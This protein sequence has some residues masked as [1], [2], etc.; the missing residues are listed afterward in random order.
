[1]DSDPALCVR[2]SAQQSDGPWFCSAVTRWTVRGPP[3]HIAPAMG[4]QC[5]RSGCGG[6][7]V[8]GE[9]QGFHHTWLRDC[10]ALDS[11]AARARLCHMV[12]GLWEAG[13]RESFSARDSIM[14]YA[15]GR[16]RGITCY[17]HA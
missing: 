13:W 10:M 12:A 16:G 2:R 14:A 1:M 4:S 6:R 17:Y 8:K 11:A 15:W 9:A 3:L 5:H 7:K